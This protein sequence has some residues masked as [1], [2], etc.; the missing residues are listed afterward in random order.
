MAEETKTVSIS[1]ALTVALTTPV[2]VTSGKSKG[3]YTQLGILSLN[4]QEQGVYIGMDPPPAVN[5]N[6]DVTD[7]YYPFAKMSDATVEAVRAAVVAVAGDWA[8][9]VI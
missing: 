5:A 4:V 8:K 2:P 6:G 3:A 9:G 7:G 1:D